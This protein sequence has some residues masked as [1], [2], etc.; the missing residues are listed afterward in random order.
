M[1]KTNKEPKK[2]SKWI[3]WL[4]TEEQASCGAACWGERRLSG[5]WLELAVEGFWKEVELGRPL[6]QRKD[7]ASWG[8]GKGQ[9]F[10]SDILLLRAN[11]NKSGQMVEVH[12]LQGMTWHDATLKEKLMSPTPVGKHSS[13]SS[14][15]ALGFSLRSSKE[16]QRGCKPDAFNS[17]AFS[18]LASGQE[19]LPMSF[20]KT[21]VSGC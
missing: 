6:T 11:L 5:E 3:W 14:Y 17:K 20:G 12:P 1:Q 13:N 15:P 19:R 9:E 21:T 18:H 4:D 16:G 8:L 7:R 10:H 2:A